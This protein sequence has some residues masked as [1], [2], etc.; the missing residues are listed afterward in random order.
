[1]AEETEAKA[2]GMKRDAVAKEVKEAAAR[3]LARLRPCDA[4]VAALH[5]RHAGGCAGVCLHVPLP[6]LRQSH[7]FR[8]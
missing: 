4:P 6:D 5:R 8:T 3:G 1:M 2:A 7:T